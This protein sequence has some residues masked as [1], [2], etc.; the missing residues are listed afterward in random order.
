M[1]QGFVAGPIREGDPLLIGLVIPMMAAH[2]FEWG[3]RAVFPAFSAADPAH[4]LPHAFLLPLAASLYVTWMAVVNLRR[5]PVQ[6]ARH[7]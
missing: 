2:L 4:P 7:I 5:E 6:V 1:L 3:R